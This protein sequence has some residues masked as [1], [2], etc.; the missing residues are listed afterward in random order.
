MMGRVSPDSRGDPR[1]IET[2][3]DE[4]GGVRLAATGVFDGMSSSDR[5]IATAWPGNSGVRDDTPTP[6]VRVANR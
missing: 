4:R 5:I 2:G 1:K 3:G 6:V